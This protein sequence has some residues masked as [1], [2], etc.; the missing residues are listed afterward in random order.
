MAK[1]EGFNFKIRHCTLCLI[2]ILGMTATS[3]NT[4]RILGA[5]SMPALSH[6]LIFQAL[7]RELAERGHEVVVISPFSLPE[8]KPSNYT[9][10][11]IPVSMGDIGDMMKVIIS[12]QRT[13]LNEHLWLW[14]KSAYVCESQL[15]YPTLKEF[16][17]PDI[18]GSNNTFDLVIVEGFFMDCMVGFAHAFNAPLAVVV[19]QY[20]IPWADDMAGVPDALAHVPHVF[21]PYSQNMNFLERLHNT[22]F[23]AFTKLYRRYVSL[24]QQNEIA[25]KYFGPSMPPLW[26]L[27][28]NASLIFTNGHHILTPIRPTMPNYVEIGGLH[29]NP[30]P[31]AL[32]KDLQEYM[33]SRKKIILFSLGSLIN[34]HNIP[35]DRLREIMEFFEKM[36]DYN[37]IWRWDGQQDRLPLSLPSN[38]FL[39]PWL[40]QQSILAHKHLVAFITHGGLLSM[41]EATYHAVPLVGFPFYGDQKLNM[42]HAEESGLAVK[43]D[44][45]TFT[46]TE[47]ENAVR[48]VLNDP[49]RLQRVKEISR[50]F[51]DQ[52]ESPVDRAVFW[53]EY[54][55]RH[56]GAMHLRASST[57]LRWYEYH[58]LDVLLAVIISSLVAV[59]ILYKLLY[60][61][62]KVLLPPKTFKSVKTD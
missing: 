38:V 13:P 53:T 62:L 49:S 56:K 40:P 9:E 30:N 8:P 52:K 5:F 37:F 36:K 4:A 39:S 25:K 12:P 34:S 55:I 26:E 54:V 59:F 42:K 10:V 60:V 27:E 47:L 51:K 15:S 1:T 57:N 31:P 24:P 61:V 11:F 28:Q 48:K 16:I 45:F 50:I 58:L 14:S 19:T 7:M 23:T 3:V 33:D 17:K 29:I 2:I 41:L 22:L 32:S 18:K 20:G 21:L 43:L 44:F 6:H 46:K 35:T